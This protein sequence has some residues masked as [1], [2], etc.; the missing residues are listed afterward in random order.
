MRPVFVAALLAAWA[1]ASSCGETHASGPIPPP[2]IYFGQDLCDECSMII[3]EERYAG[4][5]GLREGKRVR[6]LLFDDIGE[7]FEFEPP[8]ADELVYFVHDLGNAQCIEASAAFFLRA[9]TLRTPMGTGVAAF[10]TAAERDVA[11]KEYP[12]DK[13]TFEELCRRE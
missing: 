8:S 4:A 7:M 12:G 13:P 9:Q 3:S 5:I 1:I 10:A 6:H 2:K 11:A